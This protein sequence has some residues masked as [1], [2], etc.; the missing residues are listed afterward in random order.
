LF[1]LAFWHAALWKD[2]SLKPTPPF[3]WRANGLITLTTDFGLQDPFVGIMKAV[4]LG[5][6]S[7]ARIVDLTHGILPHWPAEA[8]FWLSK[9]LSYFAPGTVHVAV[10]DPGVG[11]TRRILLVAVA[12]QLLLA[13]DNGLLG[14]VLEQYSPQGVWELRPELQTS[15]FSARVS[16]TFHGRDL[17]AP[18]AAALASGQLPPSQLGMP[19]ENWVPGWIDEPV[20]DANKISGV[21]VTIDHFGNLIS[22]ISGPALRRLTDPHVLL[23]GRSLPLRRTYGDVPPGECL[24]LVNSFDSL[25]IACSQGSAA[26]VLGLERGAPVVVQDSVRRR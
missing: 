1:E 12:E 13:P 22:N 21:I 19:S 11:T 2:A 26:R 25:E 10:V 15:V 20:E 16:A 9:S 3:S 18:A 4:I 7:A 5:R 8:G 14:P 24:A 17:F 6:F 23:A